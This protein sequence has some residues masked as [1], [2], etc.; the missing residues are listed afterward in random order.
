M[1][2]IVRRALAAGAVPALAALAGLSPAA[3]LP[4]AATAAVAAPV[5]PP[6]PGDY[7]QSARCIA[8]LP[9]LEPVTDGVSAPQRMLGYTRLWD[10]SRGDGVTVAVVDTGVRPS[11]AL[12]DRLEGA[13]D[14]IAPTRSGQQGRVDCDGH[15]TLVA[16]VVAGAP[17]AGTGFAGVAPGARILSIRQSSERYAPKGSSGGT[18]G[19]SETLATAIDL[20]VKSGAD[21]VNVSADECGP[22]VTTNNASLTAA[23]ERAVRENVVVVV[24]AGNLGQ[25]EGCDTQNVPG[26][27]AVTGATPANVPAALTVGS[28]SGAG[29]PSEFSLAG[30][31][32][33]VAAPGEDVVSTNPHPEGRGQVDAVATADGTAPING[34]SFSAAYVSGIVAL[35]RARFPDLTAEQVVNRIRATAE[36]PAGPGERNID[37]GSG[38]VDPRM[39]LT[40]VLPEEGDAGAVGGAAAAADRAS[41]LAPAASGGDDGATAR[42]VAVAGAT[43]LLVA[44]AVVLAAV[45]VR[46]RAAP[47]GSTTAA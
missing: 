13:G 3:L 28:V 14:L 15:G 16:G 29:T 47:G 23:V 17:D 38:M 1:T 18:A 22:A 30:D 44:L 24:A 12:G 8:D 7:E 9:A 6:G 35:V 34:T 33:D 42:T 32:V 37:V 2:R 26:K 20:A 5:A 10:L 45:A 40:A 31:W 11:D 25:R 43:A 4:A 46:R 41:G 21:V 27:A 19:T 39:A 36:H